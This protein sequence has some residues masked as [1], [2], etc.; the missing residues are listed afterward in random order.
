M[1][2]TYKGNEKDYP[3]YDNFDIIEVNY[4]KDIPID[5]EGLMGVPITFMDKYNP[6]QFE[7]V[8]KMSTTSIDK[9]NYGYPYINGK[10][11]FARIIIKNKNPKK[12]K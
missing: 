2:K 4:V 1:F 5:Y 3:K 12:S 11:K 9:Y 8:A 6:N 7:I 10:K